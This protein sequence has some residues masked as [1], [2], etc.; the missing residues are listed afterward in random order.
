MRLWTLDGSRSIAWYEILSLRTGSTREKYTIPP[1]GYG[2]GE[3][4]EEMEMASPREKSAIA[5]TEVG[6]WF[7]PSLLKGHPDSV[8]LSFFTLAERGERRRGNETKEGRTV[9]LVRPYLNNPL[10][11]VWGIPEFFTQ[12]LHRWSFVIPLIPHVETRLQERHPVL[13]DLRR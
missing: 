12:S 3:R 5:P 2:E 9:C 10:T 6:G 1:S 4:S 11:A 8:F 7:K 13:V